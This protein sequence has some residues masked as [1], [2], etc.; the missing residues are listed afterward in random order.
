[1]EIIQLIEW[2]LREKKKGIIVWGFIVTAAIL[3]QQR[4]KVKV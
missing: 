3:L 2:L 4:I 1:M